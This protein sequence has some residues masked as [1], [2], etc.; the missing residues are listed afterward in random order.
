MLFI[1]INFGYAF[2]RIGQLSTDVVSVPL[3]LLS[4]AICITGLVWTHK[5]F[6]KAK[7]MGA[8]PSVSGKKS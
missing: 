5:R 6:K 3:L 8:K 2:K 4:A 7:P 1:L